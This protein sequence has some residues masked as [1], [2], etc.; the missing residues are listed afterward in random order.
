MNNNFYRPVWTCG[1]YNKEHHA[2]LMYNLLEGISYYFEDDSADVIGEI[3][4]AERNGDFSMDAVSEATLISEESL[5]PFFTELTSYNLIT[6]ECPTAEGI[7]DYRKRLSEYKCHKTQTVERTTQEKLPFSVSSAEMEYA[8]RVGGV[9]NVMFELTY[10][11][12]EQCIHCYNPGATRNNSEVSHRGDRDELKLEDYK[13]I[14]DELYEQGLTKVCLSGGDPFS[15]SVAWDIIDYLYQKGIAT[16]IFTNGQRVVDKVDK[17]ADYFP[18]VVGVSIY[19]GK[20]EDHD[21]ITRIKGSWEKSMRVVKRLSELAVPMNIKCCVMR[22]N[23]KS[24]YMVADIAKQYGAVPQFEISLTDSIDGDICVSR[25]LRLTPDLL[26]I[27]LRDDNIPLYVGKEA[28][29]YGGQSRNMEGVACGA[30]DNSF[31]IT[32]EGNLQPCCAFPCSFGNLKEESLE[33]ILQSK[34]LQ[35]WRNTKLKDYEECGKHDYCDYCNLCSGVNYTQHGT[36]LKAGENNCYVA[37]IRYEL[38]IKMEKGFDPLNGKTI[39]ECLSSV[40][41]HVHDLKRDYEHKNFRD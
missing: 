15:K 3:L 20:A 12:S 29:N 38:G 26:E 11:C 35:K 4:K 28:P 14:I 22:P 5:E 8:K 25:N 1:R 23:V 36:P 41:V 24:Y 18:L 34:T 27:V 17:L 6:K 10:N 2:A 32:P 33:T 30:G 19:S 16:M 31:C 7:A 9:T 21:Y 40:F 13:R 37:K 39:Q